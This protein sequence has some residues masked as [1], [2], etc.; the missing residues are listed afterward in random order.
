M[1][2]RSTP[3]QS[4]LSDEDCITAYQKDGNLAILSTLFERY[5]TLIFGACLKYLKNP[6]DSEDATM[7]IFEV[8]AQKLKTHQVETFRSWLY[9]LTRNHCLQIIRKRSNGT[10]TEDYDEQRVYSQAI[11]HP[12]EEFEALASETALKD[13]LD[14][15]PDAQKQSIELFY[16]ESKS[17]QEIAELMVTD[18]EQVRSYIQNGRR[19]LRICLDRHAVKPK[20]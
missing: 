14:K 9:I 2:W 8:L 7:E 19:N 18:K 5:I 13:C 16:F 10:L 11:T 20:L 15:L 1:K 6:S 17:Y 3:I 12:I 4:V